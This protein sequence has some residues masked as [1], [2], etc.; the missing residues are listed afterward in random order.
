M[1]PM[2]RAA[3]AAAIL[4]SGLSS[5][6]CVHT[7]SGSGSGGA[8]R[9]DGHGAIGDKWRNAVDPCYPERYNH[10]ARQAVV[11]PFAQQVHNGHVLNQ[12][13]FNWYF[14]F[15]TDKLTPA[16][17]EKL[18]SLARVR[19]APDS[20]LYIQ[21]ARDIPAN[22]DTAKIAAV[23]DD[24][25]AKRAAAIQKYMAGQPALTPVTYEIFVHDPAVPSIYSEFGAGAWRNSRQGYSGNASGGSATG[26]T[27][28]GG[29]GGTPGGTAG[30]AG[31]GGGTGA[32]Q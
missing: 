10:A 18:D 25:D 32:R 2:M 16:G 1:N 3:A 23:R 15:G 5:L 31:T 20:K 22:T 14:E 6:G 9:A 13:L 11:A 29:G 28:T 26:A 30:G 24:L 19:P 8:A 4:V 27:A 17:A 21:T 12:T 7:G